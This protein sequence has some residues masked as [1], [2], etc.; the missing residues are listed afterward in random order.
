V[1]L[2]LLGVRAVNQFGF[3]GRKAEGWVQA[4]ALTYVL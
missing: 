2:F 1:L 4:L 3:P